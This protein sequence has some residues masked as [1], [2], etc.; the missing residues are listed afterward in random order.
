MESVL[1]YSEDAA[2]HYIGEVLSI[3]L[4]YNFFF[5]FFAFFFYRNTSVL[6]FLLFNIT[7]K[8]NWWFIQGVTLPSPKYSEDRLQ[9]TPG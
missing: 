5:L 2:K 9:L 7:K 3:S 6:Y 4:N 8:M 1:E